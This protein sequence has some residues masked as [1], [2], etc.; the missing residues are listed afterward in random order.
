[1]DAPFVFHASDPQVPTA[2]VREV[3]HLS[4]VTNS[5]NPWK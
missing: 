4:L 2:P 1:V 3:A 5:R